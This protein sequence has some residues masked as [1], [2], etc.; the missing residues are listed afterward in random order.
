MA[1]LT[2]AV[3]WSCDSYKPAFSW[4]MKPDL[5]RKELSHYIVSSQEKK[6]MHYSICVS[7]YTRIN[8]SQLQHTDMQ[9]LVKETKYLQQ[10]N[11]SLLHNYISSC[12]S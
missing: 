6:F 11:S 8:T 12:T 7:S 10:I 3:I 2:N 5:G 9:S 4:A 1:T